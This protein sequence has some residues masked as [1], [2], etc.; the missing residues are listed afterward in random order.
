MVFYLLCHFSLSFFVVITFQPECLSLGWYT[1]SC[2][3]W[4]S[5]C[6]GLKCQELKQVQ[7]V[8]I[9]P[10]PTICS[11]LC[12]PERGESLAQTQGALSPMP[13]EISMNPTQIQQ[14]LIKERAKELNARTLWKLK[15]HAFL[16][17]SAANLGRRPFIY[18][19]PGANSVVTKYCN[20]AE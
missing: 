9:P 12:G 4:I 15:L 13:L 17:T 11:S 3:F 19:C 10:D 7:E 18:K 14:Y 8:G 6:G 1:N 16:S 20:N 5:K 2:M